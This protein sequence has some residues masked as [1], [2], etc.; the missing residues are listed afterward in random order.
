[1]S[2]VDALVDQLLACRTGRAF[3]RLVG[4]W[5]APVA[6]AGPD[7]APCLAAQA[8]AE[9]T[10]WRW[11]QDVP[12][13]AAV[14]PV[15]E[16][17]LAAGVPAWWSA[18]FD[19]AVQ[20]W[21]YTG[22]P[23]THG[24]GRER[25]AERTTQPEPAGTAWEAYAQ[26]PARWVV[27]SNEHVD[28]AGRRRGGVDEWEAHGL[29]DG[30]VA[31]APGVRRWRITGPVRVAEVDGPDDWVAL[32]ERFPGPVDDTSGRSLSWP[33]LAEELHGVHLTL[34]GLLT[35]RTFEG[36]GDAP[37]LWAWNVPGTV[38]A[39]PFAREELDEDPR[40]HDRDHRVWPAPHDA[41]GDPVFDEDD[42]VD[43]AGEQF[44][45]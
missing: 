2:D 24:P 18:P 13:P 19:P 29:W 37:R 10:P 30:D 26:L 7:L 25:P 3:L 27:T 43:P 22:R 34:R 11:P 12:E 9:V 45:A 28:A 41:T 20:R 8:A 36:E 23:T 14:R 6:A 5:R 17:L 40:P 16:A 38:W 31:A 21:A 42:E 44:R 32:V 15:A 33:D 4:G 39:R 35:A 1:M